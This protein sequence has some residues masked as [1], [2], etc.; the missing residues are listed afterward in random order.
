VAD[1]SREEFLAHIEPLRKDIGELVEL[2]RIANGRIAK[3]EIRLA[4]LEDRSPGRV[5]MIAGG[6]ISGLIVVLIEIA[7]YLG[8][9]K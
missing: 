3:S 2:Q 5:G 9:L 7:R 1:L 4:I 8:A 6:T